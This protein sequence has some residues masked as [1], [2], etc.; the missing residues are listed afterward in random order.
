MAAVMASTSPS[1]RGAGSDGVLAEDHLA[2][3]VLVELVAL[4]EADLV[5]EEGELGAD[6]GLDQAAALGHVVLRLGP[7]ADAGVEVEELLGGDEPLGHRPQAVLQADVVP[8]DASEPGGLVDAVDVDDVLPVGPV[9]PLLGVLVGAQQ[10]AEVGEVLGV[11]GL[12]GG[13]A[14]EDLAHVGDDDLFH[15]R[16]QP[17]GRVHGQG[18]R[19]P[20]ALDALGAARRAGE[21]LPVG[22]EAL[23]GVLALEQLAVVPVL[24]PLVVGVELVH[25][26][27]EQLAVADVDG[28]GGHVRVRVL[29]DEGVEQ[30]RVVLGEHVLLDAAAGAADAR[31]CRADRRSARRRGPWPPP[32][33]GRRAGGRSGS[34]CGCRWCRA[35]RRRGAAPRRGSSRRC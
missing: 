22:L 15:L 12:A 18:R 11:A 27:G 1:R 32:P 13:D 4:A 31:P 16:G 25:V 6:H 34:R 10:A 9:D 28:L 29:R 23:H 8:R 17:E 7:R 20:P 2:G 19:A 5:G 35:R 24:P 30:V 21:R 14:A 26:V 3:A 33:C